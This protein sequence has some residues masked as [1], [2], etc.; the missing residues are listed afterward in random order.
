VL[1]LGQV[2]PDRV[3]PVEHHLVGSSQRARVGVLDVVRS[4]SNENVSS[5]KRNFIA[6]SSSWR[7]LS[8]P[9]VQMHSV[10][11]KFEISTR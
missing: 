3:E 1:R 10:P 5:S 9:P 4:V 8:F 7:L 11:K 2:D 6:C